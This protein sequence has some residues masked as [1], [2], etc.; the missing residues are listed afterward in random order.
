MATM[1]MSSGGGSGPRRVNSRSSPFNSMKAKKDRLVRISVIPKA[2]AATKTT[3]RIW[4]FNFGKALSQ[5]GQGSFHTGTP[6]TITQQPPGC[7]PSALAV[8]RKNA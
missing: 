7:S 6:Y 1:T 4:V 3:G 5:Y 2:A 8:T